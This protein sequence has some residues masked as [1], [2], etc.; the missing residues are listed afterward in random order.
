M[1]IAERIHAAKN[2]N[3]EVHLWPTEAIVC[4]ADEFTFKIPYSKENLKLEWLEDNNPDSTN[5]HSDIDDYTVINDKD[6]LKDQF[7]KYIY[8]AEEIPEL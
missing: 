3:Y 7:N 2:V 6:F 4:N 5:Y 1:T 8:K